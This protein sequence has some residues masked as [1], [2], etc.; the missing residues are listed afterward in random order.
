MY[1]AWPTA[2]A[3]VGMCASIAYY[4]THAP[5]ERTAQIVCIE[6]H[7]KWNAS[8]WGEHWSTCDF[9]STAPK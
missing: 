3:F 2:F 8:G 5:A 6:Q 9:P 7:G 4:N 1:W